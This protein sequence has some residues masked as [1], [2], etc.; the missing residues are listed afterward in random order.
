MVLQ[1]VRPQTNLTAQPW[2]REEG[3]EGGQR[4]RYNEGGIRQGGHQERPF[5]RNPWLRGR[6]GRNLG[7]VIMKIYFSPPSLHK[8]F[9]WQMA[10]FPSQAGSQRWGQVR[11]GRSACWAQKVWRR[12]DNLEE[13]RL[14]VWQGPGSGA[15]P[16]LTAAAT[17][18]ATATPSPILRLSDS[19][20][21]AFLEQLLWPWYGSKQWVWGYKAKEIPCLS[22]LEIC[23]QRYKQ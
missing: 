13:M 4:I 10:G 16:W 9:K 18:V 12:C 15:L 1:S 3:E 17:T 2:C 19:I 20:Q 5:V 21:L 6:W 7:A 11:L 8:E 23:K 22:Y 14:L